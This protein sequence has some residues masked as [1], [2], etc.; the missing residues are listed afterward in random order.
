MDNDNTECFQA[1]SLHNLSKR[2]HLPTWRKIFAI[3]IFVILVSPLL[4][5][6]LYPPITHTSPQEA[7]KEVV[8]AVLSPVGRITFYIAIASALMLGYAELM[9]RYGSPR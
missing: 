2:E 5:I 3:V 8:Y 9:R 7:V 4:F 1:F 6:L